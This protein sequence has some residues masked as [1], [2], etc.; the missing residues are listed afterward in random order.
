MRRS[1]AACGGKAT[2]NKMA[3]HAM[4]ANQYNARKAQAR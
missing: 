4:A 2:R 3:G 1:V